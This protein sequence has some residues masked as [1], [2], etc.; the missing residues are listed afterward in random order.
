MCSIMSHYLCSKN[1][2]ARSLLSL[3]LSA[4]TG[5]LSPKHSKCF[6]WHTTGSFN[7]RWP[8][9]FE[10]T[11]GFL[12]CLL[13]REGEHWLGWALRVSSTC[14][15]SPVLQKNHCPRPWGRN[16]ALRLLCHEKSMANTPEN[17]TPQRIGEG[18]IVPHTLSF[19]LHLRC[20]MK[21]QIPLA[22]HS[23]HLWAYDQSWD[24]AGVLTKRTVHLLCMLEHW[25]VWAL[26]TGLFQ[27]ILTAT[28]IQVRQK[29]WFMTLL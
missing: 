18:E 25:K 4:V 28:E 13:C 7:W 1:A 6:Y 17:V 9:S 27:W 8:P 22:A 5:L 12:T 15:V 19:T 24:K 14:W 21:G 29:R 23:V 26:L 16:R 10:F 11:L 2:E 3:Y 20:S